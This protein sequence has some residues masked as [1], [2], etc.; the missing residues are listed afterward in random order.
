MQPEPRYLLLSGL[1]DTDKR[2]FDALISVLCKNTKGW[3]PVTALQPQGKLNYLSSALA[4][5]SSSFFKAAS[6]SALETPSLTFFGAPS[7]MSL[8]SFRPRPVISRTALMT[9]TLAAPDRKST[10]LNSSHSQIS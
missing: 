7:T 10:R 3:R 8:A 9:D 1:E 6:A 4:P 2:V 5:A